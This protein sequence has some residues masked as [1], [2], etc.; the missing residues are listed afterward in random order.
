MTTD[1]IK[2]VR[3]Q[4][5]DDEA[6]AR[7][8]SAGGYEPQT[9]H[10][11]PDGP[12]HV[13]VLLFAEDRMIGDPP[14]AVE[15]YDEPFAVVIG[16]RAEHRHIARWDPARVLA[17]VEAKRRILEEHGPDER[18][19]WECRACAGRYGDDGYPIPC[20]TVRLV[21]LPFAGREGYLDE[22]RP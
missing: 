8:I 7:V 22:W 19:P 6:I 21:A 18:H 11:G 1:M 3:A 5:D 20:P 2:W 16:G 4:L 9:W 14:E 13:G 15:R 12:G 10:S 17:E